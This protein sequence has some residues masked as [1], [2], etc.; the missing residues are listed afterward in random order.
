[1]FLEK[2]YNNI[3]YFPE[4]IAFCINEDFFS[5]G[6]LGE[7]IS[8]ISE[9]LIKYK[10]NKSEPIAIL[11]NNDIETY[12]SIVAV[13]MYGACYVPIN[14]THPKERNILILNQINP[15]IILSS[16]PIQ[17]D[18]SVVIQTKN[19]QSSFDS[20]I[21]KKQEKDNLLYILFTSGST[22]IPKGVAITHGNVDAFIENFLDAG[23][24]LNEE[25][26]FLQIYD[27]TF[28]A[29]VHCYL[30]PLRLGA[31]VYTVAQGSVKYLQAYKLMKKHDLTFAKFP[32]SVL[33]YLRPHFKEIKLE[34]LKYSLLG[35]EPLFAEILREWKNCV[36][37]AEIHNVYGPTEATVN[38]HIFKWNSEISDK[39]IYNG[40]LTIGKTFGD[41]KA[42]IVDTE[43]R[44]VSEGET[45]EM[46]LA[47]DQLTQGYY[48]MPEKNQ[49]A[50]FI[51]ET[52]GKSYRFY[53]TGDTVFCD[54]DGDYIFCGRNDNQ[55]QIQGFRVELTEIEHNANT[56]GHA[57]NYA[58]LS[59]KTKEGVNQ[60]VLFAENPSD[61]F[62]YLSEYLRK[63]LP[64][65]MIPSK[66][67]TLN[68]FPLTPG[69]KIDRNSLKMSLND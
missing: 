14:P 29:S 16:T 40:V 28:D 12:A 42:I 50:F 57:T 43:N 8:G 17:I 27:L 4:R 21:F 55:V 6:D 11:A 32:P 31:S 49:F 19:I 52:D 7:K 20:L 25:D 56:F 67:I 35:G 64:A 47:G 2:I 34:S 46:C 44:T 61:G 13:T 18:D 10:I 41:T 51:K 3:K 63:N 68:K 9:I 39:K 58:T 65:Y 15:K 53:K 30:L 24:S 23:Y 1:M 48:K 60:I 59:K 36:P 62:E 5:Y 69:G 22:G 26:R 33:N 54:E 37:N 38:T 45:G 66:I